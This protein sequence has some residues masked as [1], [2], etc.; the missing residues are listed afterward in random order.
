MPTS[1]AAS[2][3]L[4]PGATATS[5]PSMVSL[6][7]MTAP[8]EG[9]ELLTELLDVADIGADGAIVEGAD[10]RAGPALG[11]VQDRVQ[12]LLP[13]LALHDPAGDLVDPARGLPAGRALAA[14]LVGVEA[15]HHQ[16]LL[17]VRHRA[18]NDAHAPRARH[19]PRLLP[20]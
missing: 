2:M 11:H 10:R 9:F 8:D 3:R 19:G 12:V 1:R 16:Q 13:P 18:V 20:A 6:G 4:V 17:L 7:T 14:R 15:P 5:F